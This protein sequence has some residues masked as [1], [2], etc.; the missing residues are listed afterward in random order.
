VRRVGAYLGAASLAAGILVGASLT[1]AQPAS[2]PASPASSPAASQ[3]A[4]R[5]ALPAWAPRLSATVKPASVRLGDPVAVEI[6]IRHAKGISVTL[7]LQLE[8]GKFSE[9]SRADSRK[10]LGRDGGIPTE[11]RTVW[12]R[13]G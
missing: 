13:W 9:L 7:P 5:P 8:L 4:S 6:T 1:H 12:W 2:A 3:P 11:E 10:D